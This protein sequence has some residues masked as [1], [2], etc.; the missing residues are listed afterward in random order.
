MVKT[1]LTSLNAN[2]RQRTEDMA[3]I[4]RELTTR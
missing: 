2:S 3:V 4:P 1:Y